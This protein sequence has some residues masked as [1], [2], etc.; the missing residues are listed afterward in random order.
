MESP[1]AIS[2]A[3]VIPALATAGSPASLFRLP[4]PSMYSVPLIVDVARSWPLKL[5]TFDS[6]TPTVTFWV[7]LANAY[8]CALKPETVTVYVPARRPEN[9]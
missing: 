6:P 4:L 8:C 1:T 3:T 5:T 7:E 9:E 2:R